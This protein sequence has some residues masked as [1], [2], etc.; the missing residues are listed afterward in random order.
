[1]RSISITAF[2][3]PEC[4]RRVVDSILENDTSTFTHCFV[5][6]EPVKAEDNAK[7]ISRLKD[8]FAHVDICINKE[9][10]GVRKNPFELLKRVFANDISFNLYLEDDSFLSPD[11]FDFTRFCLAN[12]QQPD[13]ICTNLYNYKS[14]P[15]FSNAVEF[16]DNFCALGVGIT[17]RQWH[18]WFEPFWFDESIRIKNRID[19]G[20]IGGWDWSI[21]AVM[22][23]FGLKV[24]A[25][26]LSRSYHIGVF[27]VH[28]QQSDYER[29][30]AKH[31][32]AKEK[33]GGFTK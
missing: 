17:E 4:L 29:M 32:Y 19:V 27:G 20:G 14:N 3:R 33:F 9:T 23:E 1:M 8:R 2:N 12:Y 5:N 21:R 30:F 25:P 10:L 6:I 28:C 24:L 31:P 15:L 22:K 18:S 11:A 16:V 26:R 7:E 13:I